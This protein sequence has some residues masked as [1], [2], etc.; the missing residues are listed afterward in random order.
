[1]A[2]IVMAEVVEPCSH[3]IDLHTATAGRMNLPQVRC[4]LGDAETRRCAEAFGL[5]IMIHSPAPHR[6]P[7]V[8]GKLAVAPGRLKEALD[9][10]RLD[11]ARVDRACW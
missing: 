1:M 10:G 4:D 9:A 11:V 3:G 6:S 8:S 5:P 7:F 2:K